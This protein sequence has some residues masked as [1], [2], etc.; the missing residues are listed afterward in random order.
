MYVSLLT[1]NAIIKKFRKLKIIIPLQPMA[2]TERPFKY[3][4]LVIRLL[5][6]ILLT[7]VCLTPWLSHR[8]LASFSVCSQITVDESSVGPKVR[9]TPPLTWLA[10][11]LHQRN[12]AI[13]LAFS[14]Q[15]SGSTCALICLSEG[16]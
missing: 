3:K 10:Q 6:G 11:G 4:L 8:A 16:A 9:M 15:S 13:P 5:N 7:F 2:K 12:G 14:G 1:R